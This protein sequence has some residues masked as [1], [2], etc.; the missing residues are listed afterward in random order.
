MKKFKDIEFKYP[1]FTE[2]TDVVVQ[3]IMT[4]VWSL[5]REIEKYEKELKPYRQG[6]KDNETIKALK[7]ENQALK[8]KEYFYDTYC[9]SQEEIER[10]EKWCSQHPC[11]GGVSGG[12]F[13]WK[14]IPTGLGVIKEVSCSC[15]DSY[16]IQGLE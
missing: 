1:I 13:C 11:R 14:I 16:L 15:G 8:A 10:G 4:N 12:N 7:E 2:P 6:T 3:N 9:F 5:Y